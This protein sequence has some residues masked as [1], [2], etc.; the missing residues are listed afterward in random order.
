MKKRIIASPTHESGYVRSPWLDK[1]AAATLLG[2]SVHTLK[3][4]RSLHWQSGIHYQHLNSRTVRYH[5]ELL[6][7]WL[8]TRSNPELHQRAIEAY[9]A[10]LPSNQPKVRG[11]RSS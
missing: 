9:L 6:L 8:A 3:P 4:Y 10:S 2:I 7:D 1:H 11:R 5:R